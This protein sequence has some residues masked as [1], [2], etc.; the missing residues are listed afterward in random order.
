MSAKSRVRACSLPSRSSGSLYISD[1][2][3]DMTVYRFSPVKVIE[4]AKLKV[5]RIAIPLVFET[6][7]ALVQEVAKND[8]MEDDA[9]D[10]LSGGAMS[11]ALVSLLSSF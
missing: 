4:Y 9:E 6:C 11:A 8:L 7:R 10:L 5:A 2:T 3:S 1:I